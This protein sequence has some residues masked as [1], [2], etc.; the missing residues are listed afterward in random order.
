MWMMSVALVSMLGC[1]SVRKAQQGIMANP[2]DPNAWVDL[3][4]AYRRRLRKESAREAYQRALNLDA[5]NEDARDGLAATQGRVHRDPVV[6]EAMQNP[7]NDE[8]W[9]DAGDYYASLGMAEEALS[10]YTYAL[11]L[12]ATDSEWQRKIAAMAGVDHLIELLGNQIDSMGD[13]G[14]GDLA[15]RLRESGR[16]DE[17]CDFYRRA[18]SMDPTDTE[19][20]DRIAEC[21]GVQGGQNGASG[22]GTVT[23]GGG[24]AA[25]TD[26]LR[27]R[28]F[29]NPELL[30]ELG[31]AH[32]QAGELEDAAN[33]LHSALLLQPTNGNTLEMYVAVTGKTRLQ[34]L[35]QLIEEVP[36][37]D[38][39]IGEMGDQMLA[40]GRPQEALVY[41]RRAVEIDDDDPEWNSKKNLLEGILSAR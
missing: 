13:E 14:I 40:D 1:T 19:W 29:S 7:T 26:I 39:L 24:S 21:D 15:D 16:I 11:Q 30:Q 35:E 3:G 22:G 27:S 12:D 38:E 6:R 31:L 32:A 5:Q 41:Y 4:D 28:V 20:L 37:N 23:D 18:L 33:Y 36:E 10:A 25:A 9:G 2:A 17:A 8:A 34:V